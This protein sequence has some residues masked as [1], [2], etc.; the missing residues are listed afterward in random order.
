MSSPRREVLESLCV[1]ALIIAVLWFVARPL[2]YKGYVWVMQ[3]NP[4][5]YVR[6][7]TELDTP[8]THAYI[9]ECMEDGI[10]THHEYSEIWSL[11][12]HRY[13]AKLRKR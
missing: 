8:E 4:S 2:A 12:C 10:V 9:V 5:A 1:Y 13:D 3:V 6:I 11:H 7:A